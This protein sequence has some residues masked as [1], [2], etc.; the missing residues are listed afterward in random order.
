MSVT[1]RQ[2]FLSVYDKGITEYHNRLI[3]KSVWL[4]YEYAHKYQSKSLLLSCVNGYV[5]VLLFL[6]LL[7]KIIIFIL[8]SSYSTLTC[9]AFV[10]HYNLIFATGN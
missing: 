2:V 10:E 4:V 1:K 6:F 8:S 9:Q 7:I 5:Q 3:Y